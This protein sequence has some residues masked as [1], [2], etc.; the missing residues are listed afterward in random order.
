MTFSRMHIGL[1]GIVSIFT[2]VISPVVQNSSASFPFPLTDLQVPAYIILIF[3]AI[4]C[5]LLAV[6]YWGWVRFF[7]ML[8]LMM[9][10]YL[11]TMSW[12]GSVE[13]LSGAPIESLSWGWIFLVIWS[14]MIINCMF[15]NEEEKTPISI[16]DHLMGWLSAITI[17]ALTGLIIWISYSPK[18]EKINNVNILSAVFWTGKV[19]SISGVMLSTAYPSISNLILERSNDSLSFYVSSG[20]KMISIPNWLTYDRL[21]YSTVLIWEVPYTITAD[22]TI[23]SYTGTSLGKAILPQ[24]IQ[25]AIV[26]EENWV[27]SILRDTGI[28]IFPW[29]YWEILSII[30]TKNGK[31]IVWISKSETGY[32]LYK[33]GISISQQENQLTQLAISPDG[34]SIMAMLTESDW[35]KS[36]FKNWNKIEKLEKW[37]IE[38]SLRMNGNDSIYTIEHDSTIEVIHN[39]TLLDR[40]FDEIREIFIENESSNFIY[41]GR[42][43]GEKTYCLYTRFK[44]NLCGLSGYMNPRLSPDGTSV[45]YAWFKDGAWWIYR[46][47]TPIIRN[48]GYP[49]RDD[50]S[51]DYAFFDITNPNY[52]LFIRHTDV[53]YQLY[54]KWAWIYG[55]W[56]DVWL[57]ASFWYDNKIIMSVQDDK[58]WRIIEF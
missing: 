54:T 38:W 32:T 10:G 19:E 15:S 20:T 41:F 13:S 46:N 1:L 2:G 56:K 39:G 37:Y 33:D 18:N 24:S 30:W 26:M 53:W 22:G 49:N 6:R 36:I 51:Q 7:G 57:D 28:Q 47:A 17:L 16:W 25:W 45:I 3:L 42:P 31:H 23:L 4:I 48:T 50:I 8:V 29:T 14:G 27:V 21:P 35:T 9:I 12:N 40:K 34:E 52:Y 43:L 11:F 58:W 44:W 5:I 55:N